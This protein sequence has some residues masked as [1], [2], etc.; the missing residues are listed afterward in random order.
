MP[1]TTHEAFI[2]AITAAV[3][4]RASDEDRAKLAGIKL[5]YGAGAPGLR[6]VTYFQRWKGTDREAP[7]AAF[8]EVCALGQE[9]WIQ[10]AGTTLHELAHVVAGHKAAHGPDWKHAAERLGIRRLRAAGHRYYLA[11]FAPWLRELIAAMPKP[12]EGE[13]VNMLAQ[14][15][16]GPNGKP[17]KIK[18]CG[19][20]KGS[21]GGK[22]GGVGS[23]SRLRLFQCEC[24]PPVKARVA[25]DTFAA[26]CDCCSSGFKLIQKA[27]A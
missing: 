15:L 12:D 17:I 3:L 5:T 6:G 23:G 20:G 8:V 19:V 22:S 25:R 2:H 26:T 18:P 21:K 14:M 27:E 16:A 9:N 24:D 1:T 7:A 11:S 13:P 10:V 4:A